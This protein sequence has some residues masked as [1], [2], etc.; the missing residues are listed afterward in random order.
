MDL[1]GTDRLYNT[2]RQTVFDISNVDSLCDIHGVSYL[3]RIMPRRARC[4]WRYRRRTPDLT[5]LFRLFLMEATGLP[6]WHA[7]CILIRIAATK[8]ILAFISIFP[9]R[10]SVYV[11]VQRC[12]RFLWYRSEWRRWNSCKWRPQSCKRRYRREVTENQYQWIIH[13]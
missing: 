10:L 9:R 11:D 12:V 5:I 1:I 13:F 7:V 2:L 4:W 8:S 3:R 6:R